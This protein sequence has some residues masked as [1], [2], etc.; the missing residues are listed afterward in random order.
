MVFNR[1]ILLTLQVYSICAAAVVKTDYNVVALEFSVTRQNLVKLAVTKR[2]DYPDT[3]YNK[4]LFY[5]CDL[6]IGSDRQKVSVDIDTGSSDLWVIDA[7]SGAP[8]AFGSYD[9]STSSSYKYV[10]PGFAI[11]YADGS[12]A[13]GNWVQDTV[14]LGSSNGPKLQAQQF[15]DATQTTIGWGILGIGFPALESAQTQYANVPFALKDQGYISKAAY[16]LYLGSLDSS[17][18]TVLFGGI[19]NAKYSGSLTSVA[20]TSDNRLNVDVGSVTINGNTID[21]GKSVTLDSGSTISYLPASVV[22]QIAQAVGAT[23]YNSQYDFYYWDNNTS[24]TDIKFNFDGVSVTM[25]KE[26]T[27]GPIYDANNNIIA[28]NSLL[29]QTNEQ[30]AVL[31]DNFIRNAYIVYDLDARQV[32]MAEVKF[33]QDTDIQPIG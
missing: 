23:N 6:Y 8:V 18:G 20:V 25:A 5:I 15:G 1:L 11:Q 32:S 2:D 22:Q 30:Y 14:L 28:E 16:S 10:E 26:Y 13:T 3:L 9:P 4:G 7:S 33:T 17:T 19:D 24:A 29:I 21:V 12:T 31:G 27:V